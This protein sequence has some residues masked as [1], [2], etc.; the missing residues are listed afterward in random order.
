[1]HRAE[2]DLITKVEDY[3]TAH[4]NDPNP[5]LCTATAADILANVARGCV[6]LRAV[7]Q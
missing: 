3:F 1:V 7:N 4:N 2:P 5:F 6:P